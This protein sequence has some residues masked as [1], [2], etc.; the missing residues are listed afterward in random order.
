MDDEDDFVHLLQ[1]ILLA[2]QQGDELEYE[3]ACIGMGI[4]VETFVKSR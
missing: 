1:L 2:E 3:L 4:Q